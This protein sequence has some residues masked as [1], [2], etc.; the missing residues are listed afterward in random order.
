MSEIIPAVT[1]SECPGP[2][3]CERCLSCLAHCGC[4]VMRRIPDTP[5]PRYPAGTPE[6]EQYA[7]ELRTELKKWAAGEPPYPY[8][9]EG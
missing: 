9:E 4:E 5:G 8:P 2:I 6:Y 1:C 3:E 7:E